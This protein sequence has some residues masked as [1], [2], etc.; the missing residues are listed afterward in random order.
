MVGSNNSVG[1]KS[2]YQSKPLIA[3]LR[4]IIRDYP[5]GVGIL[6]E[7]IQ[8]A[9]DAR[10]T[11]V[12]ITLDWRTHKADRL[13]S[14]RMV[15]LMGSAMLV[16]NDRVFTDRDFDSIRSLGQSEKLQTKVDLCQLKIYFIIQLKQ[17]SKKMDGQLLT[18]IYL[19]KSIALIFM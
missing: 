2:F 13:P 3:R 15:Q 4:G 6:K 18:S 5:E 9:D 16:Y 14:D 7:L 19:L 11:R 17:H 1:G 10:A 8:N 12:E